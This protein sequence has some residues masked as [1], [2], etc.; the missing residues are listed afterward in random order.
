[1]PFG[2]HDFY[3]IDSTGEW[4]TATAVRGSMVWFAPDECDLWL[5]DDRGYGTV[6]RESNRWKE[7]RDLEHRV[8]IERPPEGY[9]WASPCG[10]RVTD[11]WWILGPDGKRLMML[12]P[13]WQSNAVQRV[14]KGKLLALL[15]GGLSEPVILEL[16]P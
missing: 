13:P 15:H 8:D 16:V 1:V 11:D 10:Y 12:P 6:L 14:W 4:L 3:V 9:P 5:A 2:V 7:V